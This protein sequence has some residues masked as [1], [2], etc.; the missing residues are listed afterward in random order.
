MSRARRKTACRR[1]SVARART[2]GLFATEA[3][4]QMN[5]EAMP[6]N[7]RRNPGRRVCSPA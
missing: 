6:A 7:G 3:A 4:A 1:G 2:I 5:M